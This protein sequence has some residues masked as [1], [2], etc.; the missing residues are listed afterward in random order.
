[1]RTTV[2]AGPGPDVTRCV[3]VGIVGKPAPTATEARPIPERLSR[4]AAGAGERSVG[5]RDERYW[6]PCQT[7]KQRNPFCKIPGCPLSPAWQT[8]RVLK[9]H[10]SA[11]SQSYENQLAGFTGKRLSLWSL[12]TKV[13]RH[14][15]PLT[16]SLPFFLSFQDRAEVWAPVAITASNTGPHTHIITVPFL[17]FSNFGQEA[18]DVNDGVPF[19]LAAHHLGRLTKGGSRVRKGAVNGLVLPGWQVELAVSGESLNV[20]PEVKVSSF[21]GF[22]DFCRV[23]EFSM[24]V[25]KFHLPLE[26]PGSFL[27]PLIVEESPTAHPLFKFPLTCLRLTLEDKL[28]FLRH[29]TVE[30]VDGFVLLPRKVGAQ[31]PQHITLYPRDIELD[32]VG[33]GQGFLGLFHSGEWQR[34]QTWTSAC[35]GIQM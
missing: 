29:D 10:A 1:M 12:T 8:F 22:L 28:T 21:A 14:P 27:G 34:E 33:Q 26:C 19:P 13:S 3:V 9:R 18:A 15:L 7:G 32:P 20:H 11:R 25:G 2:M 17:S 23:A 16:L 4:T 24:Q 5:R 31:Y 30:E 6:N 35:R